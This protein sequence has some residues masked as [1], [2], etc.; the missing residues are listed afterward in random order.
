MSTFQ[1]QY[2]SFSCNPDLGL[3]SLHVQNSAVNIQNA[4]LGVT[5]Q[6]GQT[7][8]VDLVNGWQDFTE[9]VTNAL[10]SCH[11]ILDQI[12]YSVHSPSGLNYRLVFAMARQIPLFLWKLDIQNLADQPVRIGKIDLL[13]IGGKDIR[14]SISLQNVPDQNTLAFFCNGWQSWAFTASYGIK[15]R[16]SRS[17]LG[18]LANP[19]IVNA[20]TPVTTRQ[21]HFSSDFYGVLGDRIN[22]EGLLIGFLSQQQHFGSLEVD[23]NDRIYFNLWANGDHTI[24]NPGCSMETDWAVLTPMEIDDPDPF[25]IYLEA[26]ARENK[27]KKIPMEA[28]LGWCS[29]YQFYTDI[30][31]DKMQS[32][33]NA[34]IKLQEKLPLRLFQIDDGFEAQVGDWFDFKPTF[35]EGLMPLAKDIKEAG[36][37]PGLWLAPF[38]CHPRARLIKDHP[39]YILRT[40]TG[41]MVNAGFVW[42][43]LTTALDISVP[44]ALDYACRVI[45]TAVHQWGYP[46]LKLDFLYAAAI[47]GKRY[48]STLTRAQILRKGMEALRKAAGE[49]TFILGCG[50]PLGSGLGLV[51]AN[52]IG[53][54][55]SGSWMPEFNGIKLFFN[56]EPN[57]PSAF[58]SIQNIITR[59]PLHQRWWIND[60]DC[61]LVR[62][63][64]QLTLPEVQ[65]LATSIA[66]TG[67]SLLLSDDLPAL[68]EDRL[69]LAE[70]LA[71]VIGQRGRVIDWFDKI[72]PHKIRLDLKGVSGNWSV[73]ALFNWEDQPV[74]KQILADEFNFM[75]GNYHVRSFWD[76]EIIQA[77]IGEP[78]WKGEIATHGVVLLAVRPV[79]DGHVQYLG[80]DL[81]FSQGYEISSW[82]EDRSGL[83]IEFSLGRKTKGNIYLFIPE[84]IK[85]AML[86]NQELRWEN[87][88]PW[89]YNFYV[90]I[91]G[92]EHLQLK[93]K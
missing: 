50:M 9:I 45:D 72:T 2:Y 86:G 61:L 37:L 36:L 19:M 14:S 88:S 23:L 67:G 69:H 41:R 71:P 32:N 26:S 5:L 68:S 31:I 63:D 3:F 8:F 74:Y 73:F 80:G 92:K 93:F 76:G 21:G 75:D 85:A 49:E 81:H 33:L 62:S 78:L 59:A 48:N 20:G 56:K 24:L 66:M 39:E 7:Q 40:E 87:R 1:N 57:V 54:D 25:Q 42:N 58:R 12:E 60:P 28:P 6:K 17:R 10:P 55:V 13:K 29:W 46:Y 70:V 52:R 83:D 11:G 27:V 79:I 51:E 53:A 77:G 34:V 84:E 91:D 18:P 89:I 44:E 22:R 30:S 82:N 43:S 65:S 38:I 64:T 4:C 35:P 90:E 47:P 16:Q 15:D